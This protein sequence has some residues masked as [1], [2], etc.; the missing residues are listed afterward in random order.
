LSEWQAV[1]IAA[2]V[3]SIEEITTV[4]LLRLDE[5]IAGMP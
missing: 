3:A 1:G 2:S 5:V 4:V